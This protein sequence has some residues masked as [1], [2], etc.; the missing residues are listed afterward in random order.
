MENLSY[1]HPLAVVE[2]T[3]LIDSGTKVWH[4]AH[5]RAGATIGK[6]C[7]I[8]K[9]VFIDA[10]VVVGSRAKIQNNVSLYTGVII[11]D[12]VF[13]GPHVCFTNDLLPRAIN[14]DGTVKNA[15]DWVVTETTIGLGASLG[16]NSTIVAGANV[17]RWCLV[18]AG[19]VVTKPLPPY[20]LAYGSPARVR[21]IVAPSGEI[22]SR[23][24]KAGR[25]PCRDGSF[26][27]IE[28]TWVRDA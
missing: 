10:G 21:G 4:F 25:Y 22:V 6:E 27:L 13:I 12:G 20:A 11:E 1:I 7:V 2:D 16:G 24:Y 8:G 5:I 18:G 26:V 19:S 9:N 14:P 28:D 3:A 15:T 23:E 17:G